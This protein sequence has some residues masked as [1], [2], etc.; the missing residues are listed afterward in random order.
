M[1][2][3]F[4]LVCTAL[5]LV[6]AAPQAS[7]ETITLYTSMPKKSAVDTI[8]AFE[9]ANPGSKIKLFRAPTGNLLSKLRAEV[10]A[11]APQA[12]VLMIADEITMESIKAE[13]WLMS[14]PDAPVASLPKGSYDPD[15]TYFGTKIMATV[16]VYN[17]KAASRP[18]SW[19]DLVGP[20]NKGASVM[21]SAVTSGAALANLAHMVALPGYGWPYVEQL[22]ANGMMVVNA[23]GEVRDVVASGARKYGVLLDYMAVQAMH[24]GSPI[25][26]VYPRE[27]VAATYQPVAVLKGSKH[28]AEAKKLIAFLLSPKGEALAVEQGYRPLGKAAPPKGFPPPSEIRIAPVDTKGS[29][30]NADAMRKRFDAIFAK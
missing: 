10:A 15:M 7:A 4:A 2:V 19:K 21:P 12:D 9:K 11:G 14:W 20:A 1:N 24:K 28:A 30:A 26:M 16:L 18:T 6:A 27:G 17:T 5:T 25:G 29:L 22:A 23:N 3:R 13:G 8:Q